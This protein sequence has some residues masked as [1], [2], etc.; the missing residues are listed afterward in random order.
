MTKAKKEEVVANVAELL[1]GA[2]G[3]YSIDFTGLTVA[4]AIR[5][6][7]E[8]KQAGVAYK[9]AKNTL[10]KRALE[11]VGGYDHVL[12]RFV[13]QTGIAVGYD[14]PAA[15]ARVLNT[16]ID[17]K[18]DIPKLN[19]VLIEKELMEG[20]RLKEIAAMPSRKEILG[21][22]VGALNAPASGIVGAINAV[23]RDLA[24]VIEEVAKQKSGA[25]A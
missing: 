17:P 3:V 1:D 21:S 15:P 4:N 19:F 25:A 2:S 6:R 24:S 16:F 8:F 12:D 9:V 14:D 18:V 7:R 10:I 20:S 5:L 11:Q 13:G 23:M 22:I